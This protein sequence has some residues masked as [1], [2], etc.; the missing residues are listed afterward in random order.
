MFFRTGA[1]EPA[2]VLSETTRASDDGRRF[3]TDITGNRRQC[4]SGK[5]LN[6]AFAGLH[7]FFGN[8]LDHQFRTGAEIVLVLTELSRVQDLI[9]GCEHTSGTFI[10][11]CL[12]LLLTSIMHPCDLEGAQMLATLQ[13]DIAQKLIQ[14]CQGGIPIDSQV[15]PVHRQTVSFDP[16]VKRAAWSLPLLPLVVTLEAYSLLTR[17]Q[18]PC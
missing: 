16:Q 5:N 13:P 3:F 2:L 7:V 8:Y 18:V 14:R 1:T 17:L 9:E 15:H 4:I 6:R 10:P 11:A 12:Q